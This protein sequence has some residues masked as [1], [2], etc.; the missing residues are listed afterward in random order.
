MANEEVRKIHNF[1]RKMDPIPSFFMHHRFEM[2][3]VKNSDRIAVI[4]GDKKI[5][6]RQLNELAN[7]I[8]AYLQ[9]VVPEEDVQ[10]KPIIVMMERNEWIIASILAIWKL[11][12]FF[13]PI[14]DD[15]QQRLLQINCDRRIQID[16]VLTNFDNTHF[17]IDVPKR[18]KIIDV[19]TI[20]ARRQTSLSKN[21]LGLSQKHPADTFAYVFL[22]SGTTGEPKRCIIT[23][24][25]L[26]ILTESMINDFKLREFDVKLLQWAQISFDLFIH[27]FLVSLIAVPGTMT[28]IP[29]AYRSDLKYIERLCISNQ[30]SAICVTPLFAS[31]FLLEMTDKA[32]N[33]MR[34][35]FVGADAFYLNSY[36]K[37]EEKLPK[38]ASIVNAYGLTEATITSAV[39]TEKINYITS[40]GLVPVG[41]SL[42]GIQVYIVDPSIK[43]L[44]PIGTI[45]EI[46]ICGKTVGKGDVKC[47]TVNFIC[48]QP[49]MMTGDVARILPDGNIDYI[50][51][52][53]TSF[54]K[55]LGFRVNPLEIEHCVTKHLG[56]KI[57]EVRVF[58]AE[59]EFEQKII[60]LVYKAKNKE[61]V[62]DDEIRNLIKSQLPYYMNP[63]IIQSIDVIPVTTNGKTD[64]RALRELCLTHQ[65][66]N[67][68]FEEKL[69][70]ALRKIKN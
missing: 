52:R 59:K 44:S 6:Y 70:G 50:G 62:L 35:V 18:I 31:T 66:S 39:F 32:I 5:S 33:N 9:S 15:M 10:K 68:K 49:V 30:I 12:G 65:K 19:R 38:N 56:H 41:K 55:V 21:N 26:S 17:E 51:R 23:H 54:F 20:W 53:D 37:L 57:E 11:G 58:S 7:A 40:S 34:F 13:L 3:C 45:G 64:L 67:R 25:G 42:L 8:A 29:R 36:R 2:N 43:M 16:F 46:C 22:T 69:I 63:N 24:Q 60:C 1:N 28:I 4:S 14:S 27:D 47:T 61:T 48:D